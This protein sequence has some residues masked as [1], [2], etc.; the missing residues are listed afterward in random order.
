MI[1]TYK[2]A[3]LYSIPMIL[4]LLIV[5]FNCFKYYF[6]PGDRKIPFIWIVIPVIFLFMTIRAVLIWLGF[7]SIQLHLLIALILLLQGFNSFLLFMKTYNKN[8][9]LIKQKDDFFNN[10]S[11]ELKTPLYGLSGSIDLIYNSNDKTK[12]LEENLGIITSSVKR[13]EE[14][15]ETLLTLNEFENMDNEIIRTSINNDSNIQNIMI[16]DDVKVNRD[17]MSEQLKSIV[18]N[19][20]IISVENP[21]DALEILETYEMNLIFSDIKMPVMDGFDFVREC[22]KMKLNT[23]IYL[24]SANLVRTN[25]QRAHDS[26]ANGFLSKPITIK[27]LKQMTHYVILHKKD[28]NENTTIR[29]ERDSKKLF[30]YDILRR[31]KKRSNS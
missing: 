13:L 3:P 29:D 15:V 16:V 19:C 30:L 25:K 24:F 1:F 8:I 4:I 9:L 11:H 18:E 5:I 23:P 20:N 27:Q 21:H 14:Q 28:N 26:G 31:N 10:L 6:K 7:V 17:I 22:R 12:Y 2:I